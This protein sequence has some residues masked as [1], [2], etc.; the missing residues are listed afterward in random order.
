MSPSPPRG[1]LVLTVMLLAG[2]GGGGLGSQT[3]PP[4]TTTPTSPT[5]VTTTAP[6][7]PRTILVQEYEFG[8]KLSQQT[9]SAGKVT[10]VMGNIGSLTHNFDLIG[11]MDGPFLV[12]GQ[13]STITV[14]L[15][16]GTYTYVCSVKYHAAEGMQGTLTVT[17]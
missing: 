4:P 13:T 7:P 2:C 8:F 9:I 11:A 5:L 3:S 6:L 15:K 10:F 12:P 14:T 1:L 17:R 16:P